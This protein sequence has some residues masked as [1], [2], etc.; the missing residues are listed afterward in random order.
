MKKLARISLFVSMFGA[1]LMPVFAQKT[2]TASA[3][4]TATGYT[5]ASD[6]KYVEGTYIANW[7]AR[8]EDCV[9]L[10]KYATSFY[11]GSYTYETLSKKSGGSSKET[12]PTSALYYALQDMMEEE[13]DKI[14]TYDGTKSMYAY[15]DCV[16]SNTS[17][18]SIF[19]LGDIVTSS[20]NSADIWNREHT[21]PKSKGVVPDST[22]N[23]TADIMTLRATD[24]TENSRR[25]NK[26]YGESSGY[27]DPDK[28]GEDIRGDCA[29]MVL[30]TYTRW[31]NTSKMW[32]TSGVI[33]SLNVLL[34]WMEEDPVDTWEMGR[35]DAVQSITGTRNVFVDYPEYAWLLF[36]K[37]A[38]TDMVTPSGIA[39]GGSAVPVPPSDEE[40]PDDPVTTPTTPTKPTT[41]AE[42]VNAAYALKAGE[43]L[44]GTYT[45]TGKVTNVK[46]YDSY[47]T[48]ICLTFAV[49]GLEDKPI[50]CY[51]MRDNQN[52]DNKNIKAG[53]TITVT[54]TLKNHS[55]T[56]EFDKPT[57]ISVGDV[58][59]TTV[60]AE[61]IVNAAYALET[62]E[63][64][65]G[66]YTLTGKVTNVKE[67]DSYS[68]NICLTFA[69][70]GLEDKPIYCYWMRDNQNGNNKDI[71]VGDTIT[72][73]GI[74][75]NQKGTVEF[76]KPTL[77]SVAG[78][79][80]PDASDES[81]NTSDNAENPMMAGCG[82]SM[83]LS[84]VGVG[85]I[86]A[87]AVILKR[88]KE[89]E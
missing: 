76:D 21:W 83:G 17:K 48:N 55:N 52:G 60:T 30:Y 39:S 79:G 36:G 41:P 82:A 86:T 19:Y 28:N 46:E 40:T 62:G 89:N 77:I 88:K 45:L 6:V 71:V 9:F 29:R 8:E 25:G 66:T 18:V 85:M 5:K 24:T 65:D 84:L 43:T 67:Y 23:D 63:M 14:T 35:N 72:V 34:K 15:T 80:A 56:V 53:D 68:T 87:G 22:V 54:G 64:L 58:P 81:D 74:L 33:E 59:D 13:H 70:E 61:E 12:A 38:P 20:W 50:Y 42:I 27:Y 51:W 7:G 37:S 11:T 4:T 2:Q 16:S 73:T 69:V 3:A 49:E 44:D 78:K 26:A 10:S 32:G 1:M 57:L 75:K 47:S 31:G